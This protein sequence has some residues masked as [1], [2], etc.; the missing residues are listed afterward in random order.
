MFH[1]SMLLLLTWTNSPIWHS[2]IKQNNGSLSLIVFP[3]PQITFGNRPVRYH[4]ESTKKGPNMLQADMS[5]ILNDTGG[6]AEV[7]MYIGV[8]L[9]AEI[10]LLISNSRNQHEVMW[11]Y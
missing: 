4:Q 11:K 3:R 5:K 2:A 9:R 8:I 10:D 1:L 7:L 6:L